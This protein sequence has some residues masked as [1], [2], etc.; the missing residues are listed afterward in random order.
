[1]KTPN[2]V[3]NNKV[4]KMP[5][6]AKVCNYNRLLGVQVETSN[7]LSQKTWHIK[8]WESTGHVP[9][10]PACPSRGMSR[11]LHVFQ[12][13]L[14]LLGDTAQVSSLLSM[15]VQKCPKEKNSLQ[16]CFQRPKWA[17]QSTF[18]II[19]W[20]KMRFDT[21]R[22]KGQGR[23]QGGSKGPKPDLHLNPHRLKRPWMCCQ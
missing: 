22:I 5:L 18:W 3:S 4:Q 15:Y 6:N 20:N 14:I 9:L 12:K 17:T 19:V 13:K 8:C 11:S 7:S 2:N 16:K 23:A 10:T 21:K 1:M